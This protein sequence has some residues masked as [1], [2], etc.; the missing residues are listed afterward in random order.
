M[1]EKQEFVY[2]CVVCGC[3][4]S[5][6]I[7]DEAKNDEQKNQAAAHLVCPKCFKLGYSLSICKC[8]AI[9]SMDK[10]QKSYIHELLFN[11]ADDR[12]KG[13]DEK[14]LF[15]SFESLYKKSY[16]LVLDKCGKCSDNDNF[17]VTGIV[18]YNNTIEI[19]LIKESTKFEEP[20]MIEAEIKEK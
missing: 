10:I 7:P 5:G 3:D 16:M 6:I 15:E 9:Y 11:N 1:E 19:G 2:S 17:I 8:G 12:I 14:G 18:D 4:T 20:D 13:N